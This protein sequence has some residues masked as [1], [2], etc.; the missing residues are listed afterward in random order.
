[1]YQFGALLGLFLSVSFIHVPFFVLSIY[2][3]R[4]IG[5]VA[6]KVAGAEYALPR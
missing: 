3:G 1:L 4:I 5:R 6:A 2:D